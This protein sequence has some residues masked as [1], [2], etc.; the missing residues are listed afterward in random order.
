MTTFKKW[1][2]KEDIFGFDK[3]LIN[4]PKK[5]EEEESPIV[6]INIE[7]VMEP[8]LKMPL[9]D[10]LPNLK[11]INQIQW[12]EHNGAIRMVI[13]PLGSFKS[14]IRGMQTDL[15]GN[16][17]WICKKIIPYK[18]IM[19]ADIQDDENLANKLFEEIEEIKQ[20]ES[21]IG[22]YSNLEN[23]VVNL[24]KR[25]QNPNVIPKIFIF[26]GVRE[27][28]HNENYVIYFECKGQG[29]ET[30]GSGRLEQFCIDM[31]Y[32]RKTGLIRSYGHDVQSKMKGHS[33][34]PQ[35]SEWDEYFSPAQSVRE[36][37]DCICSAL[38]TY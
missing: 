6:P 33:W 4:Q 30:P 12:G 8:L 10:K 13:S 29:A 34:T 36:I 24:T 15:E 25:C 35:P 2:L 32:N 27:V 20:L 37:T 22:N 5:T 9:N 7:L 17:S 11:F 16:E 1:L 28:K 14:I 38:S 3:L 26:K 23:L 18:D 19:A 31:S 21:A